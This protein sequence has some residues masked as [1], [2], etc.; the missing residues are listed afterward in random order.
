MASR[1]RR[2]PFGI[3][4]ASWLAAL[5]TAG[6]TSTMR[7]ADSSPAQ[8]GIELPTIGIIFRQFGWRWRLTFQTYFSSQVMKD[9]RDNLHAGYVR[10]GWIPDWIA[11]EHHRA[12]YSEDEA[13]RSICGSGLHAMIIVPAVAQDSQGIDHLLE[14][15]RLFF[16]RYTRREPGCIKWAEIGNENDLPANGYRDV[17]SYA[18]YYA[19]VAPI[20]ASFGIPVITSGASGE[21]RPWTASLAAILVG[22]PSPPPVDGF[23][24]HPYGVPATEM[25]AAVMAMRTAAARGNAPIPPVYVTEIGERSPDALYEA[26]VDLA[27]ATPAVTIY[28]YRAQPGEDR[29]YALKDNP[30]LYAAVQSAWTA[31]FS[32]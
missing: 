9:I 24:F 11:R 30:Q 4:V 26:L 17:R 20:V 2:F 1:G 29:R 10:T 16:T 12:W 19:T 27:R 25:N 18:S 5:L 14:N 6:T 13:M 3:V 8:L 28:E 22:L 21:D 32:H 31:A 7:I 15:V 23:G